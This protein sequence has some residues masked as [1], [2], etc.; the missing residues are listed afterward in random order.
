[1]APGCPGPW[2]H[3]EGAMDQGYAG[4][5]VR[6]AYTPLTPFSDSSSGFRR[7]SHF[8]FS[9]AIWRSYFLLLNPQSRLLRP[10]RIR[11]LRLMTGRGIT[12]THETEPLPLG[13]CIRPFSQSLRPGNRETS[14]SRFVETL[15]PIASLVFIQR[16]LDS[17]SILVCAT[18]TP[19]S[20]HDRGC[21]VY[22]G[23]LLCLQLVCA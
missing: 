22:Y 6:G 13:R 20:D 12:R 17:E 1:M 5:T 16:P 19:V 23:A 14:I 11:D 4:F 15:T 3:Q 2:H 10:K 18:R 7:W 8:G 9:L 21:R